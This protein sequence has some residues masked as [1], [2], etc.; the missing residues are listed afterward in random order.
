HEATEDCRRWTDRCPS[1]LVV[2][3]A[4]LHELDNV[5]DAEHGVDDLQPRDWHC[6]PFRPSQA[7]RN[8]SCDADGDWP[9]DSTVRTENDGSSTSTTFDV[10]GMPVR[11]TY[12]TSM[13][14]P[15]LCLRSTVA[16]SSGR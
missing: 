8:A 1:R 4:T 15:G 13:V 3:S 12:S 10:F 2:S 9:A 14:S 6:Y 7:A 5:A 11:S 16:T